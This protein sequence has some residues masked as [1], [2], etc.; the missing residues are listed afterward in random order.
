MYGV[1]DGKETGM[2]ANFGQTPRAME[3]PPNERGQATRKAGWMGNVRSL[4]LHPFETCMTPSGDVSR[5]L[6]I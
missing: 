2:T 5:Q 1:I 3:F 4:A 6:N